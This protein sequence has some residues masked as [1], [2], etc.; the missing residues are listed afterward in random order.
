MHE[1]KIRRGS[2]VL[3]LILGISLIGTLLAPVFWWL[4][5]KDLLFTV[6]GQVADARVVGSHYSGAVDRPSGAHLGPHSAAHIFVYQFTDAAGAV[7]DFTELIRVDDPSPAVG[8]TIQIEYLPVF[9]DA[10][11]HHDR[12]PAKVFIRFA[13]IAVVLF[14]YLRRIAQPPVPIGP[15]STNPSRSESRHA[16][17][18]G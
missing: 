7:Q 10:E 2:A 6:W 9:G 17:D 1:D 8:E 11:R 13:I 12:N 4:V 5:G 15:T 18:Q 14:I 16:D 3:P